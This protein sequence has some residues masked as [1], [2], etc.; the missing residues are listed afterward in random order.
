MVTVENTL[1]LNFF[2]RKTKDASALE[3]NGHTDV[4]CD[5]VWGAACSNKHVSFEHYFVHAAFE[6]SVIKEATSVQNGPGEASGDGLWNAAWKKHA[7][8]NS[9]GIFLF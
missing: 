1:A 8:C 2:F 6:C 4:S 3:N 5:G 9:T 7:C